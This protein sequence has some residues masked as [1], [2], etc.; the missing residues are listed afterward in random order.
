MGEGTRKKKKRQK[1][2]HPVPIVDHF[3]PVLKRRPLASRSSWPTP[4]Y[5]S[6]GLQC[7]GTTRPTSFL[8][9]VR[10]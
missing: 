1:K 9:S 8:R 6:S 2:K 10:A 7:A 3:V 5:Q 4:A